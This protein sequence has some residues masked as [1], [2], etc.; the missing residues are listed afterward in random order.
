MRGREGAFNEP[1]APSQI[2]LAQA[3]HADSPFSIRRLQS[4]GR[5][6]N[7]SDGTQEGSSSSGTVM[8]VPGSGAPP[9]L[10]PLSRGCGHTKRSPCRSSQAK[11]VAQA[12][13]LAAS[14]PPWGM[15]VQAP[16]PSKDHPWYLRGRTGST[17]PIIPCT[18][19][20]P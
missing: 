9:P 19:E 15:R 20:G 11:C 7:V 2:C 10:P 3:Y 12:R 13:G 6:R 14:Q 16:P 18:V 17:E 5:S 8:M 4:Y 1:P